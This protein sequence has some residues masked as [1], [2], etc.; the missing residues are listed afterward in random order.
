MLWNKSINC[1][2]YINGPTI[3]EEIIKTLLWKVIVSF[4]YIII[5]TFYNSVF[6]SNYISY[7]TCLS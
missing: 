3:C 7:D 4:I 5:I 2:K 6:I 1:V